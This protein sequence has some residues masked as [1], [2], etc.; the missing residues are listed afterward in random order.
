MK[1]DIERRNKAI[2]RWGLIVI[3]AIDV[4]LLGINWRLG[5]SPQV[6]VG[7]LKRLEM[8]EKAYRADTVRLQGFQKELPT[9]QKQWDEFYTS[10]FRPKGTGYSA[11]S[12]DLGE[13]STS[14]G[15]RMDNIT[16]DQH[17]ADSHG[18]IEVEIAT[19]VE[20]DYGS[21]INFLDK[22]EHSNNFYVLDSLTLASSNAGKVR[23]NIHLRTYFRT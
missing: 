20:G 19:A 22:L 17:N 9:D 18:L 8:L 23:L 2:F 21:L 11:I 15:L 12:A 3:L 13:L 16:Y 6:P 5:Q 1:Q 14:A 10:N 7:E 4:V